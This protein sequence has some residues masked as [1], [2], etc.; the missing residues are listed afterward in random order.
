MGSKITSEAKD[1]GDRIEPAG[2]EKHLAPD[3]ELADTTGR[4]VRLSDYR[5]VSPV[6]LVLTRG[7]A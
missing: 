3:F 7:F 4:P 2:A 5:G 6:V 1:V